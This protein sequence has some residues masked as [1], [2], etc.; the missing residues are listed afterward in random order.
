MAKNLTNIY[1]GVEKKDQLGGMIAYM[2]I[3]WDKLSWKKPEN[4]R[5]RWVLLEDEYDEWR[6]S[7]NR[8]AES[9]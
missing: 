1:V 2:W 6:E 4:T 8:W 9:R 5:M 7:F 3:V